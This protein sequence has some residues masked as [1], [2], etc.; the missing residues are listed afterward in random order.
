M[1]EFLEGSINVVG[2]RDIDIAFVVV[3]IKSKAALKGAG[4]VNVEFIV[5]FD[6]VH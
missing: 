2:H 5:G 1:V 3:P 4:P 6:H